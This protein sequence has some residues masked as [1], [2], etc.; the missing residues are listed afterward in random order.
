MQSKLNLW[1]GYDGGMM[2][3][4]FWSMVSQH[5]YS[6]PMLL[7]VCI[8]CKTFFVVGTWIRFAFIFYHRNFRWDEPLSSWDCWTSKTFHII[9]D[10]Y[11]SR[12]VAW[13][14]VAYN[15]HTHRKPCFT[16]SSSFLQKS[17]SRIFPRAHITDSFY[18]S[19]K[20]LSFSQPMSFF[21][22]NKFK[23][24]KN[25]WKISKTCAFQKFGISIFR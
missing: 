1:R 14:H 6:T 3:E 18:S 9:W 20:F 22:V 17:K 15:T 25:G 13:T 19:F 21:I 5:T 12:F 4:Y 11:V 10:L 2:R 23:N 24:L 7:R 16:Y 8:N